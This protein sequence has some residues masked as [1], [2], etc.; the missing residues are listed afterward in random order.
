MDTAPESEPAADRLHGVRPECHRR[1]A[2]RLH[3]RAVKRRVPRLQQAAREQPRA[4][5]RHRVGGLPEPPRKG[6]AGAGRFSIPGADRR[7]VNHGA[8]R[9][10]DRQHLERRGTRHAVRLP[11]REPPEHEV[12]QARVQPLRAPG[13]GAQEHRV[14]RVVV[15]AVIGLQR[16]VVERR[17]RPGI[18]SGVEPVRRAWKQ[19]TI[20]CLLELLLGLA[21]QAPHLAQHHAAAHR[22]VLFPALGFEFDAASLLVEVEPIETRKEGR[23]DIHREQVLVVGEVPR[24]EVVGGAVFGRHGVHG[25]AQRAAHHREERAPA[26]KALAAAHHQMLEDVGEAARIRRRSEEAHQEGAV[27]ERRIHVIVPRAGRHVDVLRELSVEH[28]DA[29]AIPAFETRSCRRGRG[30]QDD[31]LLARLCLGPTRHVA[32]SQGTPRATLGS[33]VETTRVQGV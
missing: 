6:H 31:Q 15:A 28:R 29:S 25:R 24:G 17:N 32:P 1:A 30:G 21:H 5:G 10:L 19:G 12:A 23:V 26:G 8:S 22:R 3:Q 9:R 4:H 11:A 2:G 14:G 18:A 33:T 7:I 27:L 16:L 20:Q 13:S